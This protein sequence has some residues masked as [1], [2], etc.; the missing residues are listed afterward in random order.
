MLSPVTQRYGKALQMFS[1]SPVVRIMGSTEPQGFGESVSGVRR[2]E[3]LSN[4]SKKINFTI[5]I[6]FNNYQGFDECMY[7]T[8]G[9]QYLQQG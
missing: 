3:I 5:R 6:L 8:C 7:G 9:V 1:P 2:Q 4:K